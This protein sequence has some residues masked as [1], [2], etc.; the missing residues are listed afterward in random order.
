MGIA[1]KKVKSQ[2]SYTFFIILKAKVLKIEIANI[3]SRPNK[4]NKVKEKLTEIAN[5]NL[6][7][8]EAGMDPASKNFTNNFDEI[9]VKIVTS[10]FN[11][12]LVKPGYLNENELYQFLT[13]AFDKLEIP[14][15]KFHFRKTTTKG[16]I[17]KIFYEYFFTIA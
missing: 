6:I 17:G 14:K 10:Y 4:I 16:K 9:D 7:P 1:L 12:K 8:S 2:L 11:D 13:L 5:N 15:E 3:S